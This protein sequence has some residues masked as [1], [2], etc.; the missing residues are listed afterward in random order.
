MKNHYEN[1]K[2]QTI[3]EIYLPNITGDYH[4]DD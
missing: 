2:Q 1:S 3:D 4:G